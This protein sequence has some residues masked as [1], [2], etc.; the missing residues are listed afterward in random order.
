M[1]CNKC[2]QSLKGIPTSYTVESGDSLTAIALKL[3]LCAKGPGNTLA[4]W[5]ACL[6]VAKRIADANGV[7]WAGPPT[8]AAPIR[9]G[10]VLDLSFLAGTTPAK[11]GIGLGWWLLGAVG[12]VAVAA[13]A[14]EK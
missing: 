3:G 11:K 12:V 2:Q 8:W 4:D 14:S 7:S 10:Q 1:G 5:D 9:V 13:A 6:K